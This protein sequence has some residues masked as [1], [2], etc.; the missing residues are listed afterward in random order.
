MQEEGL[1][2]VGGRVTMEKGKKI[3]SVDR[4]GKRSHKMAVW[5]K[6]FTQRTTGYR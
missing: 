1:E 3:R 4:Q 5:I 2:M 6:Y